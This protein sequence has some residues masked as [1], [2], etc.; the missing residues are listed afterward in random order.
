VKSL[1]RRARAA[2]SPQDDMAQTQWGRN[3]NSPWRAEERVRRVDAD[4][5]AYK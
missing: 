5:K 4:E 3:L 1:E 2:N